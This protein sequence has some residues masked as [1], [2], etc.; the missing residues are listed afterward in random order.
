MP[1]LETRAPRRRLILLALLAATL[2][3]VPSA[4]GMLVAASGGAAA[5]PLPDEALDDPA[6]GAEPSSI[7]I[8]V[9]TGGRVAVSPD[10][11]T[12]LGDGYALGVATDP[13]PPGSFDVSV[14]L[15]LTRD[16]SPVT[17]AVIA[18]DWDMPVMTHGPFTTPLQAVGD[19]T[20]AADF[21]FFMYGTWILD[22]S[23][24]VPDGTMLPVRIGLYVW[25]GQE[26]SP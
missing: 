16:G 11:A 8:E 21:Q 5:P 22:A 20:Y 3:A 1:D 18:V 14:T 10:D 26:D 25:P 24:T 19:G 15:R 13:Y 2:I 23:I 6:T 17:D 4:L 12:D 7:T 9:G